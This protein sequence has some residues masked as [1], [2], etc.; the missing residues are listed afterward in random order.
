MYIYKP[1]IFGWGNASYHQL[2]V[3]KNGGLYR[4]HRLIWIH[5]N[6]HRTTNSIS[7]AFRHCASIGHSSWTLLALD[8]RGSG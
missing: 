8:A 6:G 3:V 4:I 2:F 7:S 1:H 5:R